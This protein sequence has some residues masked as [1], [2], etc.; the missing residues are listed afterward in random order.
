MKHLIIAVF[1]STAF[2][3]PNL[4]S[5]DFNERVVGGLPAPDG[6]YPYYVLLHIKNGTN[7][8]MCGGSIIKYSWI[9]TVS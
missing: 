6:D 2:C 5:D 1:I 7:E 4:I 9:L 3:F 8:T